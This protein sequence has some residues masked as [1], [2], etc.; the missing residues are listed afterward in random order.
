MGA[1]I[2]ALLIYGATRLFGYPNAPALVAAGAV[3]VLALF[4]IGRES[5]RI[6]VGLIFLAAL[7]W[8]GGSQLFGAAGVAAW[9]ADIASTFSHSSTSATQQGR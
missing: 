7:F 2:L 6:L 5:L 1:L 8:Y 9:K 3:L 4:S